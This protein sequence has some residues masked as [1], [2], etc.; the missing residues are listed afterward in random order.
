MSPVT[1]IHLLS[2]TT[3]LVLGAWQLLA[4]KG[5]PRHRA[6][7]YAWVLAMAFAALSSFGL[8]S[9]TGFAR[10]AGFGP[11]HALSLFTLV[12]LAMALRHAI[13]RDVRRHRRW[14]IGAY[15]GLAGAGLFAVVVPG[16]L[17]NTMLLV[18]LPQ[19]LASAWP[20]LQLALR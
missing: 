15:G 19:A 18:E 1:L 4:R 6:L 9:E 14:V 20:A 10:L 12:S 2:A 17:L 8:R 5:G 7:G 11:I 3:A 16:R 13:R